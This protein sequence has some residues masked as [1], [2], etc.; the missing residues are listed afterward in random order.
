M[1]NIKVNKNTNEKSAQVPLPENTSWIWRDF[2]VVWKSASMSSD[3]SDT[4][5][6]CPLLRTLLPSSVFQV[7]NTNTITKGT[8]RFYTNVEIMSA[9]LERQGTQSLGQQDKLPLWGHIC[10]LHENLATFMSYGWRQGLEAELD[11]LYRKF[12]LCDY[13]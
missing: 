3:S 10:F 11:F 8:K 6:K 4:K 7:H 5:F 13:S 1:E 12:C 2:G 9:K